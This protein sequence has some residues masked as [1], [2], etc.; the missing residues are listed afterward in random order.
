MFVRVKCPVAVLRGG[1]AALLLL[2]FLSI[3]RAGGHYSISVSTNYALLC[4]NDV[5]KCANIRRHPEEIMA[6]TNNQETLSSAEFQEL[7]RRK[8]SISLVLTALTL[9]VYFGYILLLAFGQEVLAT[10]VSRSATLGIPLGIGII[11]LAWI[12]TGIY[13]RWANTKY[14]EMVARVKAKV[15]D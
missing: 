11:V 12:F 3:S 10:R 8:N 6:D 5:L 13:V 4:P 9:I 2:E 14:D 7:V 15:T 1:M